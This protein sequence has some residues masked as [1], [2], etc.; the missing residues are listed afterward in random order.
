MTDADVDGSHIRTLLLT[1]FYRQMPEIIDGGYLYIAQ[2]PLYRVKR[3]NMERYLKN[4]GQMD[5]FLI[6]GGLEDARLVASSGT[7]YES[8]RMAELITV[9]SRAT[10][11]IRA[12]ERRLPA[13][14]VEAA[15]LA[16]AL[17]EDALTEQ[18]AGRGFAGRIAERMNAGPG[19]SW[20]G[21]RAEDGTLVFVRKRGERR[22]R[23]RLDPQIARSP[24][25][26]RLNN[27]IAALGDAFAG[28]A[29][30]ERKGQESPLSGPIA[31]IETLTGQGRKGLS[32][33]R[34]KGLGE[35][36]PEQLWETTLDPEV[37]TLYQVKVEHV[38][39]A[40][41]IF[42]TLM[43]DVVEPRRDFIQSNALKV[44]NLDV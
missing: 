12:L 31:L 38:D 13:E 28:P 33:Q 36:N 20:E 2:P 7:V 44:V 10:A 1:F 42:A 41:E 32:V 15:V 29:I 26:R 16:G 25:G 8:E 35:M 3:G 6:S 5:D 43:G 37:R 23:F 24:E 22:D 14:L 9:A 30:L 21:A 18:A 11:L 40:N 27:A 17:T 4:E 34:Y 39:E 19:D